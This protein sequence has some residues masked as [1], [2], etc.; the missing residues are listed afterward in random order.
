MWRSLGGSL[1]QKG[2]THKQCARLF[3]YLAWTF[4]LALALVE[5]PGWVEGWGGLCSLASIVVAS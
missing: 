1:I 2:S 5:G 3:F 4:R